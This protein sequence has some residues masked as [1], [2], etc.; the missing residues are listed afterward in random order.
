MVKFKIRKFLGNLV[1]TLVVP[2]N[3]TYLFISK[4]HFTELSTYVHLSF[5][6]LVPI[7]EK[8]ILSFLFRVR[9]EIRSNEKSVVV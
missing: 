5:Y 4:L 2:V 6:E 3:V 1:V 9:M 7:C 8:K